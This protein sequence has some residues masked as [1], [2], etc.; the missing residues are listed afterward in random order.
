MPGC[1]NVK[2]RKMPACYFQKRMHP[3]KQALKAL[4]VI[5]AKR[6]SRRKE[7]LNIFVDKF[8]FS[9][10][11]FS[12]IVEVTKSWCLDRSCLPAVSQIPTMKK[13][14]SILLRQHFFRN[15]LPKS[16][17]RVLTATL[18]KTNVCSV[19]NIIRKPVTRQESWTCYFPVGIFR[20][21]PLWTMK[22]GTG[23]NFC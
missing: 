3:L 19:I 11:K 22:M 17:S 23:H 12:M 21:C 13:I 18:Q 16:F 10:M 2:K 14:Y 5:T 9:F 6:T 8:H 7:K 4:E 1:G 20:A 15:V